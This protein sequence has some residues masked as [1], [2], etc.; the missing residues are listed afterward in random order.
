[1]SDQLDNRRQQLEA[2]SGKDGPLS[3]R[4]PQ[5]S[6]QNR[7][8]F[9]DDGRPTPQRALLHQ[10]IVEEYLA[11]SPDV[12]RNK[13]AVVIV[14]PPGAGKSGVRAD[15]MADT[16]TRPEQWRHLDPD[17]FRDRLLD[18]MNRDGSLSKVVQ[19]EAAHLQP[20]PRELS[21]QLFVE[22][23]KLSNAA[24]KDA[25][26]R[27]DNLMI[28][29]TY[30]DPKR[31][32]DLVKSLEKKGYDVHIASVEVSPADALE[33]TQE[34]YRV[35]ALMAAEPGAQGQA[36]MGGRFVP[37]ESLATHFDEQGNA[38][39]TA[40]AQQVAAN[41]SAVQSIRQYSVSDANQP[42]R[43]DSLSQ[44]LGGMEPIDA[45]AYRTARAAGMIQALP[46]SP[47]PASTGPANQQAGTGG[48]QQPGQGQ[49]K[50]QGQGQGAGQG[51][52]QS[53]GQGKRPQHL[54]RQQGGRGDQR[55]R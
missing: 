2:L 43:L 19:P 47:K 18:S 25:V 52:G 17:A 23:A 42:A 44:R 20:S 30:S 36:A 7:A 27:G 6:V 9:G 41:R 54:N 37:A 31:L 49:G 4:S 55:E 48:Q 13:Q 38:R 51:S 12:P 15:I 26:A 40:A 39:A 1:M 10:R 35:D 34:R 28:E 22:S 46:A 32:D 5:A 3:S 50:S 21:S 33:R 14:G 45:Q 8:W 16:R 24:Q 11:E 29:G 53:S